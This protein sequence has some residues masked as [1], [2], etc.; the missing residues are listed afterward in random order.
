MNIKGHYIS[1][2][3]SLNYDSFIQKMFALEKIMGTVFLAKNECCKTERNVLQNI[4]LHL[5]RKNECAY[6][7]SHLILET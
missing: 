2:K 3:Y 4:L 5:Y 1:G 7:K 6:F